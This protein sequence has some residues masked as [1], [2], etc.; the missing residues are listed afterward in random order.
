MFPREL[1]TAYEH[2]GRIPDDFHQF[3]DGNLCLGSRLRLLSLVHRDPTLLGYAHRCLIPYLYGYSHKERFGS[4]PFDE[5]EHG[6][7]GVLDDYCSMFRVDSQDIALALLEL[8]GLRRRVA[9]KRP[10]PCGSGNLLG[11]CHHRALNR[12][13]PIQSRAAFKAEHAR[14]SRDK[15]AEAPSAWS[16]DR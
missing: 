15:A 8:L 2:G 12:L 11:R 6:A 10:C 3:R 1:P 9:N 14:L 4:L 13:R 5:L 7:K 16:K